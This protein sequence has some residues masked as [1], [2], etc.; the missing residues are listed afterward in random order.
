MI[1]GQTWIEI[2]DYNPFIKM[3]GVSR[4]ANGDIF[5]VSYRR[6]RHIIEKRLVLMGLKEENF[7]WD[8]HEL[9]VEEFNSLPK[10]S[11]RIVPS[12]LNY[13]FKIGQEVRYEALMYG[14]DIIPY[15]KVISYATGIGRVEAKC[16]LVEKSPQ[17]E[18]ILEDELIAMGE[19]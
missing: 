4:V 1:F 7:I 5:L 19:K 14:T 2:I 11:Y 9:S 6:R 17:D 8:E 16:Y 15:G 10:T 13:K 3:P 18:P 12:P